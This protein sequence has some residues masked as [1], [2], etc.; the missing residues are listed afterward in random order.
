MK[1]S[2]K[3]IVLDN[4]LRV[5]LIPKP[6]SLTASVLILVAAGS[7]YETKRINGVSHFLE[8]LCFKGTKKRPS[9]LQI[10]S[11]L[12]G[13]GVQYNAFT[14]E[15]YTG[16]YAKGA[17]RHIKKLLN[18]IS[19][20][21]LNPL[22]IEKEIEKEKG[23]I[24]GEIDMYSDLPRRRVHD[25][26]TEL[27]YGNQPA[28]WTI[29]GRKEV[30]K[31]LTRK[32]ILHYRSQHYVADATVI[33]VAGNFDAR[34]VKS[35]IENAFSDL[36]VEKKHK[37]V[38]T[39]DQQKHFGFKLQYKKTDQIHLVIAFRSYDIFDKQQYAL[40]V[41][42]DILGG[43]MSSRL[44]Q[45]IREDLG[46]GYYVRTHVEEQ[47]DHG[48]LAISAGVDH[49]KLQDVIRAV[50]KECKSIKNSVTDDEIERAKR[51]MIGNLLIDLEASDELALF[52]GVQEVLKHKTSTPDEYIKRINAVTKKDIVRVARDIFVG[53]K[54]NLALIGP[55]RNTES[56]KKLLK[57]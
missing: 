8:H 43:G 32:E 33:V 53:K 54:L 5:I 19:D 24:I 13:L 1:N 56:L 50:L 38:K 35:Q 39:I 34:V 27:L 28:G 23:V 31:R 21:Y 44:F 11:E 25:V 47:T 41:L 16:Y 3:R 36:S 46:A 14:G 40:G 29:L 12:D 30:I 7:K 4:G 45:R 20:L 52:Y 42:S 48:H 6:K 55:I 57:V 22:F 18:I 49:K 15:E 26:M 2:F 9:A 51:H 37:K 17:A 10:A